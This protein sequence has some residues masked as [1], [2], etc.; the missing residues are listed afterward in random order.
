[1]DNGYWCKGNVNYPTEVEY[2]P[3]DVV[4]I[5]KEAKADVQNLIVD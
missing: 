1:M 3:E 2:S 4:T 5:L